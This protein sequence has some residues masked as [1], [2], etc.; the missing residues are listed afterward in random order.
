V[1]K[2]I[3]RVSINDRAYLNGTNQ[4]KERFEENPP[5]TGPI[6]METHQ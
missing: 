6:L 1:T 5:M 3:G 4:L 2:D